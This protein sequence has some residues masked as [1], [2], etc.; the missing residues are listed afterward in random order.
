VSRVETVLGP[1]DAADLG[2]TFSHEHVVVSEGQESLYYPWQYDFEATR[3]VAVRRWSE[4]KAAGIGAAIDV[5][6]PDLARDVTLVREVSRSAN[7]H[8]IAATGLWRS[9]PRTF[10]D[11]DPDEIAAIFEREIRVGIGDTGVK[12]GAIKVANDSEGVTPEAKPV[13][14]AAARTL[15]AT[16]C[17]I[18]THSYAPGRVG[19]EQI[20]VFQG[21][22]AP[23]DRIAIGHSDDTT[24]VGY[25]EEI[26]QAGCFL[27]M[28]R[29]DPGD[30]PGYPSWRERAATVA[31][32]VDRGWAKQIMLG[33]DFPPTFVPAGEAP[34]DE[35]NPY[36]FVPGTV[37]P[38]LRRLGVSEEDLDT[39]MR[40]APV[41]FLTGEG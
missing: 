19:L 24:D 7:V 34:G 23:L 18:T 30:F 17:P 2:W 16:G 33:H 26:L 27:S 13:L 25:L 29:F 32:L 20:E 8:I 35:P 22:R 9:I 4:A 14:Q 39:M 40:A 28:D 11:R 6:T 15:K 21:E 36:L 10:W 5:T 37:I 3:D 1:V 38:E 41:R 12:A 31:V